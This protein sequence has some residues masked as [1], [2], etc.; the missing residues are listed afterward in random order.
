MLPP[1]ADAWDL[2][3]MALAALGLL[4]AAR[5]FAWKAAT[6]RHHGGLGWSRG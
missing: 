1:L 6:P 2:G 5:L 4:L 3:S